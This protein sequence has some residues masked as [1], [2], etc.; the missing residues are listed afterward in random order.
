MNIRGRLQEVRRVVVKVGTRVLVEK[1]GRPNQRRID[2]LAADL[3]ALR[4]RGIDVMLVSSGAVG[5][6]VEALGMKSRPKTLPELQM[7]AAVGQARLMARYQKPFTKHK[8]QVG[9]LLLTYADLTNRERHLNIRNTVNAL[10]QHQIIPIVNEND[11]VSVNEIKVGDN[12]VLAALSA[13]MIDADLLILLSTTNGFR[14]TLESGRSRTVS[15]LPCVDQEAMSHVNGKGSDLST[16][17][18]TTKLQAAQKAVDVGIATVIADGR[19]PGIIQ[20]IMSGQ[21]CGTLIA[22]PAWALHERALCARKRWIA[23]FN[24]ASGSIT[25][26]DGAKKALLENGKSLL[27]IGIRK[28]TGT[29][30]MGDIVNVRDLAGHLIA[31]GLTDYASDDIERIR[32]RNTREIREIM[33]TCEYDEVIHRDNLAVLK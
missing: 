31:T 4:K 13:I 2:A 16:G 14:K 15:Y 7:A 28:V 10:F 6:G 9:Q 20:K 22:D 8:C 30:S 1:T 27:P 18:M 32:G 19:R 24:R 33:K 3:A 25:V 23:Y 26:D 12:D 21:R 17:G 29:F 11:V 5:S